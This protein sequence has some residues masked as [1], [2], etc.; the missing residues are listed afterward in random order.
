MQAAGKWLDG[1]KRVRTQAAG[2]W[3]DGCKRVCTH[4]HRYTHKL[5]WHITHLQSKL[6]KQYIKDL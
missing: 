6:R 5:Y 2:K 3:L 1:C 4:T